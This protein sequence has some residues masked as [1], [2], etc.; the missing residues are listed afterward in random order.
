[1]H[2]WHNLG[3]FQRVSTFFYS[4][5]KWWIFLENWKYRMFY[6]Q[7][8]LSIGLLNR[9][10]GHVIITTSGSWAKLNGMPAIFAVGRIC[11]AATIGVKLKAFKKGFAGLLQVRL[12]MNMS[13][14]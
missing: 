4:T 1:M 6:I 9:S 13:V 5:P 10:P 12:G 8:L 3:E 2:A 14:F 11:W 7:E